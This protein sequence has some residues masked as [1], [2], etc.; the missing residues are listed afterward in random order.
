MSFFPP[1]QFKSLAQKLSS[2]VVE[3]SAF[4]SSIEQRLTSISDE[5]KAYRDEQEKAH[6]RTYSQLSEQAITPNEKRKNDTRRKIELSI[7]ACLAFFTLGAFVAAGIYAGIASRQLTQIRTSN[8]IARQSLQSVQRAFFSTDT[9]TI[10]LF[11]ERFPIRSDTITVASFEQSL[12]N[13][14]TTPANNVVHKMYAQLLAGEPNEI[15]FIGDAFKGSRT[16]VSPKAHI[17][18]GPVI[19]PYN[20]TG[21]DRDQ[22]PDGPGFYIWGFLLYSDV[23]PGTARHLTEYCT[24]VIPVGRVTRTKGELRQEFSRS[25]CKEHV[26]A[27]EWCEDYAEILKANP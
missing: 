22:T 4:R 17:I 1:N 14:G 18:L 13:A 5:Q 2:L 7:Q 19:V 24:R 26:C 20:E 12:V 16:Y 21:F 23:F 11:P 3:L 27:D 25:D 15:T 8:E 10:D 6:E 9:V